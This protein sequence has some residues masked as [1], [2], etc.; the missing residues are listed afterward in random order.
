MPTCE[1]RGRGFQTQLLQLFSIFH[2]KVPVMV[3]VAYSVQHD[4]LHSFSNY[5]FNI[6]NFIN[7][8]LLDHELIF[9]SSMREPFGIGCLKSCMHW[10]NAFRLCL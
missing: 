8:Y 1:P 2:F 9:L 7:V 6:N 3:Y 10:N 4:Q 5:L